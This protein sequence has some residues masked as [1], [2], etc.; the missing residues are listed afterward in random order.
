MSQYAQLPSFL[1][2]LGVLT[3]AVV[4]IGVIV[5][6]KRGHGLASTHCP[7]AGARSLVRVKVGAHYY[8]H[9]F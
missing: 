2:A 3:V 8:Y 9:D 6:P 7:E 1:I 5:D 4:A